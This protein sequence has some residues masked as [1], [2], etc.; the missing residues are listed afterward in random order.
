LNNGL[1]IEN[2]KRF[3]IRFPTTSKIGYGATVKPVYTATTIAIVEQPTA[4]VSTN[5][6]K[7]GKG[8]DSG[9]E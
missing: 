1:L 2:E 8:K 3:M 5:T 6:P 4:I 9:N 7:R